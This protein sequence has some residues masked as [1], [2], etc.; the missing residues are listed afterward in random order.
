M[1]LAGSDSVARWRLPGLVSARVVTRGEETGVVP[2]A[3]PAGA[4]RRLEGP[5]LRLPE[6]AGLA[7]WRCPA[8]SPS[9]VGLA[10]GLA[11]GAA[12]A[13]DVVTG[14]G[15]TVEAETAV[16]PKTC[17][18]LLRCSLFVMLRPSKTY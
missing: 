6:T 10:L 11:F 17:L 18:S 8:S 3:P 16:T 13:G 15:E 9:G 14:S 4:G 2:G 1:L 7:T 12:L 5:D